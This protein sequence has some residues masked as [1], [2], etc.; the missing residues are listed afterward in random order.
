MLTATTKPP[1]IIFSVTNHFR[2]FLLLS[3]SKQYTEKIQIVALDARAAE[4]L[5]NILPSLAA[6]PAELL[7]IALKIRIRGVLAQVVFLREKVRAGLEQDHLFK[8]F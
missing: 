5:G 4:E 8:D 7:T 2:P 3:P 6:Y 1:K